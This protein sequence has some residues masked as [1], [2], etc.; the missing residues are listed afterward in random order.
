MNYK[1]NIQTDLVY[2]ISYEHHV[3]TQQLIL[4]S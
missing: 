3:Q 4:R 1:G 2:K